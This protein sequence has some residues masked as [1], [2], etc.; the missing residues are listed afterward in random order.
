MLRFGL[1]AAVIVGT[2]GCGWGVFYPVAKVQSEGDAALGSVTQS[3]R[4]SVYPETVR[5][6]LYEETGSRPQPASPG[7]KSEHKIL[8]AEE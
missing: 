6:S 3:V 5:S 1:L 2:G 4:E 8:P 7:R